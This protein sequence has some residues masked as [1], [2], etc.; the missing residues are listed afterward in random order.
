MRVGR[1]DNEV[2]G[3][4]GRVLVSVTSKGHRRVLK[5]APGRLEVGF[6]LY[7]LNI[8]ELGQF[9]PVIAA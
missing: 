3:G 7:R 8:L 1:V 5:L 6:N 4:T 2:F 9:Q